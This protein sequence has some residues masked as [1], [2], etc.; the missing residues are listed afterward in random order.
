MDVEV[1]KRKRKAP[2]VIKT[3]APPRN[4]KVWKEGRRNETSLAT[5]KIRRERTKTKG[6]PKPYN[7]NGWNPDVSGSCS[8]FFRVELT[9]TIPDKWNKCGIPNVLSSGFELSL[10][11]PLRRVASS[12]PLRTRRGRNCLTKATSR[13]RNCLF[14]STQAS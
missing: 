10:Q 1:V 3:Q 6:Y 13:G 9:P 5:Q 2:E 14:E 11:C 12:N 8:E 4:C 7:Y